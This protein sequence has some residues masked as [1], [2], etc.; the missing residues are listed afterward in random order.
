MVR[1]HHDAGAAGAA[2]ENDVNAGSIIV[3]TRAPRRQPHAGPAG[4]GSTLLGQKL[5]GGGEDAD[6]SKVLS[7][8]KPVVTPSAASI[9]CISAVLEALKKRQDIRHVLQ[10]L[11][12]ESLLCLGRR[13]GEFAT[14]S[15]SASAV[16]VGEAG[17]LAVRAILH[18]WWPFW[19][20]PAAADMQPPPLGTVGHIA[21]PS[22]PILS[23]RW[24]IDVTMEAINAVI[25]NLGVNSGRS[26]DKNK[27]PTVVPVSRFG[28]NLRGVI[29]VVCQWK[30]CCW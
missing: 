1:R 5:S 30:S 24:A 11:V 14:G 28:P 12:T 16:A 27:L 19:E 4:S 6:P 22:R 3:E 26:L 29:G 23:S 18:S 17:W 20:I 9:K 21:R 13:K 7:S 10:Q 15:A 25:H 8:V 2:V